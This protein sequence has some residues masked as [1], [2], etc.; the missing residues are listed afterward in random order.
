MKR[1]ASL[2]LLLVASAFAGNSP[3]SE[4][5]KTLNEFVTAFDNLDWERFT[6][7]F[8]DDATMFQPRKF[9]RRADN[10]AEIESQFRQVFE[11]IRGKQTKAPFMLLHPLDVRVQTL[12]DDAAIVTFHLDDRPGVLNRRTMIWQRRKSGW[13]IVHIHA[14]ELPL[15]P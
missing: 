6:A 1:A 10:K 4:V 8:A 5:R 9:L 12:G 2:L 7:F 3:E 13:K 14:S 15:A 11:T